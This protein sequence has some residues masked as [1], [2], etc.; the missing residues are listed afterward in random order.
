MSRK[1]LAIAAVLAALLGTPA[2]AG[3]WGDGDGW[4]RGDHYE[5]GYRGDGDRYGYDDRH[6]DRQGGWRPA[7]SYQYRGSWRDHADAYYGYGGCRFVEEPILDQWGAVV[8][9]RRIRVC[10]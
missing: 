2:L 4:G 6:E 8:D 1:P 5:D 3:Q 9:Y 10:D 7:Q